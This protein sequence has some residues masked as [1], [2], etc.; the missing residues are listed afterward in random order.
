M[1]SSLPFFTTTNIIFVYPSTSIFMKGDEDGMPAWLIAQDILT[2]VKSEFVSEAMELLHAEIDAK[3]IAVNGALGALPDKNAEADNDLFIIRNL[4]KN[5]DQ[6]HETY[7]SYLDMAPG[8]Q[9][10]AKRAKRLE[11]LRKLMLAVSEISL[12]MEYADTI[13][14]WVQDASKLVAEKD[15]AAVLADSILGDENRTEMLEFILR[16]KRYLKEEL[17]TPTERKTLEKALTL[18]HKGQEDAA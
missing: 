14:G 5:R 9:V 17:L 4:I 18:A 1:A 13:D 7:S 12:L 11:D 16:S 3:R 6:M 8:Q 2:K 15:T 10:D